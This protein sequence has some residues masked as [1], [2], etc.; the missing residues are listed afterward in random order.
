MR[1]THPTGNRSDERLN[2]KEAI[3]ADSIWLVVDRVWC[4]RT[5]TAADLLEE[6]VFPAEVLPDAKVPY[7]VRARKCSLGLECNLLGYTCRWSYTNPN[8]DPFGA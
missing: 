3:M 8:Y 1:A 2:A 4:D 6:R 7:Q 5:Q